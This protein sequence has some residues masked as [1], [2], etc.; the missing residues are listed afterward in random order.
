MEGAYLVRI[1]HMEA[2]VKKGFLGIG[3]ILGNDTFLG[4]FKVEKSLVAGG[5]YRPLSLVTFAIEYQLFGESP[6]VSHFINVVLYA[7][8]GMLLYL[9]VLQFFH[10][11]DSLA[12]LK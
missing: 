10:N 4:F 9:V 7:L 12:F 5:R 11:N 2:I 8:T 1:Q 6:K 3:E